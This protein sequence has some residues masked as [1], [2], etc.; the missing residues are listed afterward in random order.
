[1]DFVDPDVVTCGC[2]I[3]QFDLFRVKWDLQ[4]GGEAHDSTRACPESTWGYAPECLFKNLKI[5][6]EIITTTVS[7]NHVI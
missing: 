6:I 2:R 7:F 4:Q 1:M 5:K 3:H